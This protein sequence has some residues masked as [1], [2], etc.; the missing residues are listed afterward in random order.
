MLFS[1]LLRSRD[2]SS[3]RLFPLLL[4]TVNVATVEASES[5]AA[6]VKRVQLSSLNTGGSTREEVSHHLLVRARAAQSVSL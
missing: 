3:R 6:G 5:P 2:K 4:Y 1:L